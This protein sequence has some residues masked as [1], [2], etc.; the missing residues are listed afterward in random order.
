MMK[1]NPGEIIVIPFPF[2][3]LSGRKKRPA[4]ILSVIEDKQ[5]LICVMLTSVQGKTRNDYS[6]QCWKEAGLLKPTNAKVYRLFTIS[7]VMAIKRLGKLNKKEFNEI[8]K[9]VI[10]LLGKSISIK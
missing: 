8:L 6:I 1:F 2:S 9:G 5:E 3:D 4:L 7:Q 10:A